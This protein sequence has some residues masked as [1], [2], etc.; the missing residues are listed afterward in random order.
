V[1]RD[2]DN[3]AM[4]GS[5]V[6]TAL[7]KEERR[8]H[9][10]APFWL[11]A[12]LVDH[13]Y[14]V[15]L[16]QA[17]VSI[18]IICLGGGYSPADLEIAWDANGYPAQSR[19]SIVEVSVDGAVNAPGVANINDVELALDIQVIGGMLARS[20]N[21]R[22]VELVVYFA[23]NSFQGFYNAIARAVSDRKRVISIS[24]GGDEST[25]AP[26]HIQSYDALF[27]SAAVQGISIFVASGDNGGNQLYY[28]SSSR[29]VVACGGT[30]VQSNGPYYTETGWR[31]SGGGTSALYTSAR[32]VPDVA[33]IADV[34]TGLVVRVS[35]LNSGFTPGWY[36]V[37]GTSTAAPV[38]AAI[39]A[40]TI[41]GSPSAGT[42]LVQLRAQ[43]SKFYD[44]TAGN[45]GAYT[46]QVG[47]DFVTGNGAPPRAGVQFD[48]SGTTPLPP[49]QSAGGT[50]GPAVL[51]IT[52]LV[53][54]GSALML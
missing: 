32:S 18:G 5:F 21:Q 30:A 38:W 45:N 2:F 50:L 15:P 26:Y 40:A 7:P 36:I 34:A 42:A 44:V 8:S 29:H 43:P 9:N 41:S 10:Q 13:V 17:D 24:W 19:P 52:V 39:W 16:L 28:P 20:Y 6:G 1:A 48:V 47:Y 3:Y 27:A 22:Q 33:A 54:V 37:G 14:H 11:A 12:Q 51:A 4:V 23:P 31:Y 35:T 53:A 25:W 49:L 46:A